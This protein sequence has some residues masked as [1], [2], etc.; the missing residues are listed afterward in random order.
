MSMLACNLVL[1]ALLTVLFLY[2]STEHVVFFVCYVSLQFWTK[3]H[4]NLLVNN[5]INVTAAMHM[6]D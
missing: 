4:A 1:M 2:L 3:R 6:S 5:N